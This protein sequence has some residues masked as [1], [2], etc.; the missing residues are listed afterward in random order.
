MMF[1]LFYIMIKSVYT[2]YRLHRF[3]I[4]IIFI[5]KLS[6]LFLTTKF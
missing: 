1:I 3:K 2:I 4:V 5:D 6:F